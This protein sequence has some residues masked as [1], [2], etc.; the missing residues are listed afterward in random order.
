LY[1]FWTSEEAR[2]LREV[3]EQWVDLLPACKRA[4]VVGRLR[5]PELLNEAY[6]ELAVGES[7]RRMGYAVEY[8]TEIDGDTAD[9]LVH[10]PGPSSGFLLEVLSSRP[11]EDRERNDEGWALLSKRLETV[12]GGA[13][14]AIQ[15]PFGWDRPVPPPSGDR[16]KQIV[17]N[18]R[19]WVQVGP[20][21][22]DKFRIDDITVSFLGTSPRGLTSCATFFQPFSP[23][24]EPLRGAIRHKVRKY[25]GASLSVRLS[26]VV[27]VVPDFFSGRGLGA[28]EDCVLGALRGGVTINP[29]GQIREQRYRDGG[30]FSEYPALSAVSW[31]HLNMHTGEVTHTLLRNPA[32]TYPLSDDAFPSQGTATGAP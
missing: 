17:R 24:T 1:W 10:P 5:T 31:G 9:W 13:L 20:A 11:P 7:L 27:C 22:G 16:Q 8:E 25:G 21:V 26:F 14:L 18:V 12:A 2:S 3:I 28:L 19:E 32:A 6:A 23:D 4:R 15:P 30:L 29:Q